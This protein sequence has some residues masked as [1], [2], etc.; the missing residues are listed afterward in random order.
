M[1]KSRCIKILENL[2][3]DWYIHC[4]PDEEREALQYAKNYLENGDPDE[5]E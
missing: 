3:D 2:I 5:T 1:D 4:W